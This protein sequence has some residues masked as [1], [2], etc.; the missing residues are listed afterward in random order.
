MDLISLACQ[1]V[2]LNLELDELVNYD[3]VDPH[4]VSVGVDHHEVYS[5]AGSGRLDRL[6]TMASKPLSFSGDLPNTVFT[7]QDGKNSQII[8]QHDRSVKCFIICFQ[9]CI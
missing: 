6:E 4:Q 8:Y 3:V 7:D 1:E 2:G 9:L 5:D